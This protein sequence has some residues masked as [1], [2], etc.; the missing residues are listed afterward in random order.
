MRRR[1]RRQTR[2]KRHK[3]CRVA[4]ELMSSISN[5]KSSRRLEEKANTAAKSSRAMGFLSSY[6][7]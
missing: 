5:I 7:W 6:S 1:R 4:W 2:S 3:Y